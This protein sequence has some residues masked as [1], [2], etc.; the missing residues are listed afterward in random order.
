MPHQYITRTGDVKVYQYVHKEKKR[1]PRCGNCS[2]AVRQIYSKGNVDRTV[3][4]Y[5]CPHCNFL[6]LKK[7]Y[8]KVF[9]G[10]LK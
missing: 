9:R 8:D 6:Y 10:E 5:E 7:S 2:I 1:R 3:I 4:G